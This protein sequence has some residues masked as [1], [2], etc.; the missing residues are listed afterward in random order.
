MKIFINGLEEAHDPNMTNSI[1]QFLGASIGVSGSDSFPSS[2]GLA[3]FQMP[4]LQIYD[5]VPSDAQIR[6]L[7]KGLLEYYRL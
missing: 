4:E 6:A 3:T 1:E 2:A 7:E 5:Y